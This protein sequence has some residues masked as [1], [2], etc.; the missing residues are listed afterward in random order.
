[1]AELSKGLK[2]KKNSSDMTTDVVVFFVTSRFS[3][4]SFVLKKLK[5]QFKTKTTQSNFNSNINSFFLFSSSFLLIKIFRSVW[6]VT[7]LQ[8][9]NVISHTIHWNAGNRLCILMIII[10][11]S[12]QFND[13][14]YLTIDKKLSE[15]K[16]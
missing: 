1:M 15:R 2:I 7:K 11:W 12:N 3:I 16:Y 9:F 6:V 4:F 8:P 10:D 5:V 14:S 13:C